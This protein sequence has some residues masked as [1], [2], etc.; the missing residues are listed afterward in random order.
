M[1]GLS[2]QAATLS[3]HPV[4]EMPPRLPDSIIR[5]KLATYCTSKQRLVGAQQS[6]VHYLTWRQA[7]SRCVPQNADT[8]CTKVY[9]RVLWGPSPVEGKG[10]KQA[11]AEGQVALRCR[12]HEVSAEPSGSCKAG[13]ALHQCPTL[14]RRGSG[15]YMPISPNH[16]I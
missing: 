1:T 5:Q 6:R 13:K 10:R 9:G 8:V 16:Y 3:S 2:K 12:L 15:I 7:Y 4:L 14:G 11:W